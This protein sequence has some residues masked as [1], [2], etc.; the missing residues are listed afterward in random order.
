MSSVLEKSL[1]IVELLVDQPMGMPV[2][3]IAAATSQPASGVHRT[4]QE[5][6][7]LGYVRQLQS[8]GDYALT[9]KLPALGLGFM[10]RAGI[11]DVA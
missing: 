3:V 4:L 6:A 7:R 1:A 10:G 11:T 9:I 8:G 2:T 5:L